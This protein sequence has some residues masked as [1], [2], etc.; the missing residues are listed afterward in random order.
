MTKEEKD[1][2][3]REQQAREL[4]EEAGNNYDAEQYWDEMSQY[5]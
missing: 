4:E 5:E 3:R 1:F 2:L